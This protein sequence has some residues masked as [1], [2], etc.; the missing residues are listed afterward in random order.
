LQLYATEAHILFPALAVFFLALIWGGTWQLTRAQLAAAELAV[1]VSAQQ[2]GE[3]YEAQVVRALREIDQT[4]KYV[5]YV[6]ELDR[7]RPVLEEL[8]SR[9]LLPSRRL[10][11]VSITDSGGNVIASTQARSVTSAVDR[12]YFT[13]QRPAGTLFVGHP[14]KQ[15]GKEGWT[16]HFSRRLDASDG[17]YAGSAI[18]AVAADYFVSGY[19]AAKMGENGVMGLLGTDGI[20]RVRRAGDTVWA[21]DIAP[22]PELIPADAESAG[23][24]TLSR[25]SWD[26][27]PRYTSVRRLYDFP[28]AVVVGLSAEEQLAPAF[29]GRHVRWGEASAAS[30]MLILVLAALGYMRRQLDQSRR[31]ASEEQVAHAARV[32]HLA[33]H[34]GLTGLPNRS[35]FSNLLSQSLKLAQRHTRRLAVLFLDLD[36]FKHINDTLGHEAG[37]QLL[38]E[39]AV[40]LRASVRES[41]TIAR[42]GGDEFVAMLPEIEDARVVPTIARRILAEIARPFLL[43]G[44]EFRVTASIG[45]SIYPQDGLDEQTLKKNADIAMYHAK[46]E[47]KNNFR[48]FSEKLN[49]FSLERLT[50]DSALRNALERG[51][52]AL[53][54]Q[55]KRQL[56][57]HAITGM[58]ALLRWQHPDLGTVP[59][60]QFI[61]VAEESGLIVPIG[62]WVIRTA[63]RQNRQWARQGFEGLSMAVNL[64]A[65]QFTDENLLVDIAAILTETGMDAHLLELE[66]SES[67]L[68]RDV[69]KALAILRALKALGIRIAI[70]DFGV[71]YSSLSQVDRYPLDTI[72]IDRSFIRDA[73]SPASGKLTESII[74]MGKS[75]S[76]TVVA[77]GVETKEQADFLREHAC[78][79]FQGF[80]LDRPLPAEEIAPLLL[81]QSAPANDDHSGSTTLR[82]LSTKLRSM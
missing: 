73:T 55:S 81:A 57:G 1:A 56:R 22:Y 23:V 36:R 7:R 82:A 11:V 32:E 65:R 38:K 60:L 40:R 47:G 51:E 5:K 72:K 18:V 63:C 74:A 54:Y 76:L 12:A 44:Q 50:L 58:E 6:H 43:R 37:D 42:L 9:G 16:L 49:A 17:S 67:V 70:D 68:M 80:Y 27:V 2:Q 79:E 77:Q 4:L 10:F 29:R 45:I 64:T 24:G 41:D 26:D 62:K 8:N 46:E 31:R 25:N 35:L 52:F 59:P 78:D 15:D 19:D 34:D 69:E 53:H 66:I 39:V 33:Y 75:L 48:F 13:M 21:G 28:V 20:F 30:L 71:G 14:R 3:T 61:P